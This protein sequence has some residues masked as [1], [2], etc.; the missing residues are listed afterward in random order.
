MVGF[1]LTHSLKYWPEKEGLYLSPNYSFQAA[2]AGYMT[3]ASRPKLLGKKNW[4]WD[5][6]TLSLVNA[7]LPAVAWLLQVCENS[8]SMDYEC[9]N[10]EV[11]LGGF[12]RTLWRYIR[13]K[14]RRAVTFCKAWPIC[15]LLVC[16]IFSNFFYHLLYS[17]EIVYPPIHKKD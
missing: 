6:Y 13:L 17:L 11:L 12:H 4:G 16:S 1:S 5:T 15:I 7:L 8:K 2:W 9:F 10:F 3:T 14:K